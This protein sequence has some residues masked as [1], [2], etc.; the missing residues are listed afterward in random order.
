MSAKRN[1]GP[2]AR[3]RTAFLTGKLKAYEYEAILKG[4]MILDGGVL[5]YASASNR[6]LSYS[7]RQNLIIRKI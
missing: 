5:A 6:R 1:H 7:V 4:T 2:S 3:A